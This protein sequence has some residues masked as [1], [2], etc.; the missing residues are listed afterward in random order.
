MLKFLVLN[1]HKRDYTQPKDRVSKIHTFEDNPHINHHM[2]QQ[3][4]AGGWSIQNI[5][6]LADDRRQV[7]NNIKRDSQ[8]ITDVFLAL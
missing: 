2:T 7:Y 8:T 1:P 5:E 6:W 3:Q 4:T